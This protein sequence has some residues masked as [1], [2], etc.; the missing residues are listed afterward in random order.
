MRPAHPAALNGMTPAP[1]TPGDGPSAS[2]PSDS[3]AGDLVSA[4]SANVTPDPGA[5][6]A[7][8]MMASMPAMPSGAEMDSTP[9]NGDD[10]SALRQRLATQRRELPSI[11][12]GG[13][14]RSR[15][16]IPPTFEF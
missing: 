4:A 3:A 1:P 10:L 11:S 9:E 6:D 7:V 2:G 16:G 13:V 5:D 14:R 12:V 8:T 15:R